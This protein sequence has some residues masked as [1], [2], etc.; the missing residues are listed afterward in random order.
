MITE[1]TDQMLEIHVEELSTWDKRPHKHNFFEI[2]Y[3]DQGS[4]LQCIN[5]SEFAYQAGNIFLL[6]RWIVIALKS[7]NPPATISSD[8]LI[9]SSAMKMG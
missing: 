3:I 6:P 5:Q 4:G 1:S 2:V 8:S 7:Q 9:T